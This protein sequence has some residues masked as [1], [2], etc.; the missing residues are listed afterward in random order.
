MHRSFAK[1]LALANVVSFAAAATIAGCAT[2]STATASKRAEPV[3][4]S[5][6]TAGASSPTSPNRPNVTSEEARR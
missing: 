6:A 5:T 3:V 1:F 2:D 4:N